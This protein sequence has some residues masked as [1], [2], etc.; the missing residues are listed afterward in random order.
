LHS[1]IRKEFKLEEMLIEAVHYFLS[2]Q[3]DIKEYTSYSPNKVSL[4][5]HQS[6]NSFLAWCCSDLG[7][8]FANFFVIFV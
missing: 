3:Q 1:R 2:Q 6:E 4:E 5:N 7:I 8:S